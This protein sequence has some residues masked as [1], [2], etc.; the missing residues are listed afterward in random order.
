MAN[1]DFIIV[2]AWPELR[3]KGPGSWYD[4]F[5]RGGMVRGGHS[6]LIFVNSKSK[7]LY[8]VDNGRYHTP[9]GYSRVRDVDT[10]PDL[11]ISLFAE[12]SDGTIKNIKD[13]IIEAASKEANHGGGTLYASVL[14]AVSFEKGYAYVKKQQVRGMIPYGPFILKGTNCSRFVAS[15][16]IS[17]TSSF[18]I[19]LRL[20][21]PC[22]VIPSPKR[23]IS[24]C[25]RNFYV[26]KDG[27]CNQIKRGLLSGY[28][29][30]IERK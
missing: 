5:L 15:V 23:N 24:I 26:V 3:V 17:A 16:I 21:F 10:D 2:L 20:L 11:E 29:L 12:I 28:F 27:I 8:Y 19:K 14:K 25:N 7:K 1:K 30:S 22:T 6:A 18:L 4:M 9:A 13:I